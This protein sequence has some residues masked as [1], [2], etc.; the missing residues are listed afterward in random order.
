MTESR[1]KPRERAE[2]ERF[3]DRH[4]QERGTAESLLAS[5]WNYGQHKLRWHLGNFDIK[6]ATVKRLKTDPLTLGWV[7]NMAK[8]IGELNQITPNGAPSGQSLIDLELTR[9]RA[10]LGDEAKVNDA[11]DRLR[12]ESQRRI[13]IPLV[14]LIESFTEEARVL[15]IS[16][17]EKAGYVDSIITELE[18]M[19]ESD[20]L[21]E[22]TATASAVHEDDFVSAA[23]ATATPSDGAN[24]IAS[25]VMA[26]CL[27]GL[28]GWN[29]DKWQRALD[30]S[31]KWLSDPRFYQRGERPKRPNK[32]QPVL[33]MSAILLR[34]K[35]VSI[36]AATIIFHSKASLKAWRE[37]W[38]RHAEDY[39]TLYE[40]RTQP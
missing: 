20:V 14:E 38:D 10:T 33:L 7:S 13:A 21:R 22:L 27:A 1:L 31:R 40:N 23:D 26:R 35:G 11:C 5:A 6:F 28:G 39:E 12:H 17:R 30:G 2:E 36:K 19:V 37:Q 29:A 15:R 24:W 9:L 18:G 16:D 34:N 3:V 4:T 25:Q 8:R 32:Y